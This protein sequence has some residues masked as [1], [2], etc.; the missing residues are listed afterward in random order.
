MVDYE[1]QT[2][3]TGI[4]ANQQC[5]ICQVPPNERE[6]LSRT[7]PPRTHEFTQERHRQQE[8]LRLKRSDP[9]WVYPKIN[10]AWD[11]FLLNIHEAMMTD[12]LHQL[13]KGLVP[14]LLD[15]LI[16]LLQDSSLVRPLRSGRGGMLELRHAGGTT[17]LDERF[18]C[19][20][21]FKD[22]KVFKN[23]SE[24]AQT[25]GK[26]QKSVV[27]QIVCIVA[28]LL[29]RSHPAVVYFTRAVA[30]FVFLAQY[31]SHDEETLRYL[32]L[33]L[34]QIDM[35][36]HQFAR[37]RPTTKDG[38]HHFN[39]PKLHALTHY[40]EYIERFGA[41]DNTDSEHSEAA[42]KYCIK[43]FFNRTNKRATFEEQLVG[44]NLR[45]EKILAMEDR[46]FYANTTCSRIVEANMQAQSTRIARAFSLSK[47]GLVPDTDH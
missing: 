13:L 14:Y 34:T 5:P 2:L 36:K 33:T 3:I 31:R 45:R 16:S 27:K 11:H 20:P 35:L 12:V 40:R 9:E 4:K 7:W 10:F 24:I 37:F 21:P 25:T 38:N 29:S 6:N 19:I 28:P 15:W 17:Q 30:D 41:T 46:R 26:D 47:L 43:R 44:H 23:F 1:E 22:I 42:H 32:D 18:R 39:I 8:L